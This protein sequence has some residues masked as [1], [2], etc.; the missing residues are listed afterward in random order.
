MHSQITSKKEDRVTYIVDSLGNEFIQFKLSD[1]KLI[2]NDVLDKKILDSLIVLYDNRELDYKDKIIFKDKIIN[3][4]GIT[5]TNNEKQKDNLK[6]I[7][8]NNDNSMLILE[9]E[10]NKKNKE[11]KKQKL[12][13]N[14]GFILAIILP[15]SIALL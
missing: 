11:I 7:I 15:V 12:L 6:K 3:E 14:L 13:K 1:A 4:L 5:I 8:E 9:D 2:L 10:I